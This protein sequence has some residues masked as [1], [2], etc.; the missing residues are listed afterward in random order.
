MVD[1][2]TLK[3]KW[4]QMEKNKDFSPGCCAVKQLTR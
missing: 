2:D 3:G 4:V 1:C